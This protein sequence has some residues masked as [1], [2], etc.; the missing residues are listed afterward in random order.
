MMPVL[1]SSFARRMSAV[2]RTGMMRS[3]LS[4][5]CRFH[6]AMLRIVPSKFSHTEQVQ[7]A[8][9]S[10]PP[11]MSSNTARENL[12]MMSPSMTTRSW[13]KLSFSATLC[14]PVGW[15]AQA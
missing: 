1:P 12:E 13:C 7:F 6:P 15:K 5:K 2:V 4:K 8:A 14:S 10:P 11:R 3:A 9:V